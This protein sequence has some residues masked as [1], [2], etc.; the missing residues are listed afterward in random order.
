MA[1]NSSQYTKTNIPQQCVYEQY[2]DGLKEGN[3][4]QAVALTMNTVEIREMGDGTSTKK[5]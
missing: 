1:S 4:M 3:V 5:P 2:K